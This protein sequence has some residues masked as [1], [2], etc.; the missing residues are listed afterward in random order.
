MRSLQSAAFVVVTALGCCSFIG[1]TSSG[2]FSRGG[3][4]GRPPEGGMA[5]VYRAP[6]GNSGST[7][8]GGN[9]GPTETPPTLT[10]GQPGSEGKF[11]NR[12]RPGPQPRYSTSAS[13][14]G[15]TQS[16]GSFPTTLFYATDRL[17]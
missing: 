3:Q 15:L 1:C 8:T 2:P 10:P 9:A 5:P 7:P 11:E 16:N 17:R 13:G 4:T 6:D 12:F 14:Q